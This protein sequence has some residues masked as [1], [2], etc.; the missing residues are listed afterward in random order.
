MNRPTLLMTKITKGQ[1]ER[2]LLLLK[3]LC[4]DQNHFNGNGT[5][6]EPKFIWIPTIAPTAL[7]FLNS[8]KYGSEQRN[9]LIV[10]DANTGSLYH[11]KLNANRNALQLEGEL[12]DRIADNLNELKKVTFATGFGRI[13]D[14]KLG[15][16]GLLYVLSTQNGAT[17]VCRLS[18]G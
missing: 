11:F 8:D 3:N 15:P 2:L 17:G 14:I 7:T 1:L 4:T 18:P 16:D 9:D 13:T 6:N 10:G 5:Y 12:K